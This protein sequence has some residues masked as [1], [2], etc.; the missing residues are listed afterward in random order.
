MSDSE[1]V[2]TADTD[3]PILR[4]PGFV[5]LVADA[6]VVLPLGRD[7]DLVFLAAGPVLLKQ[8]LPRLDDDGDVGQMLSMNPAMNETARVRMAPQ[9]AM[10]LAMTVIQHA[11]AN[12]LVQKGP[13]LEAIKSI[14]EQNVDAQKE[15]D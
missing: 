5:R 1:N 2:E 14:T 15:D 3:L 6:T 8:S 9:A 12:G 4:D 7:F 13:F 10:T 11:F